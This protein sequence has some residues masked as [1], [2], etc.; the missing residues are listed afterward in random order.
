[1]LSDFSHSADMNCSRTQ[2]RRSLQQTNVWELALN[3]RLRLSAELLKKVMTVRYKLS[4]AVRCF[5]TNCPLE[6]ARCSG[7]RMIY[8]LARVNG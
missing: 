6:W 5:V 4:Q 8:T 7:S 2:N 1:M 3:G